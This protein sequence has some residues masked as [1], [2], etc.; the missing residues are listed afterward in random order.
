M[1]TAFSPGKMNQRD[2]EA[3]WKQ[4]REANEAV[5]WKYRA[6]GYS[7]WQRF[8]SEALEASG[9][10]ETRPRLARDQVKVTQ[11]RMRGALMSNEQFEDIRRMLDDVWSRATDSSTGRHEY[12]VASLDS[13]GAAKG[14]YEDV[15]SPRIEA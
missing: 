3:C 11:Q 2:H 13:P 5:H 8:R 12:K 7:N 9:N 14:D 4:W 15:P 10:V 6:L 1:S